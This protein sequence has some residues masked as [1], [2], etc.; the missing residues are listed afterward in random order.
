[1]A[2]LTAGVILVH[3][4]GAL[5]GA[6]AAAL[7]MHGVASA[8]ELGATADEYCQRFALRW[9]NG[10]R[11]VARDYPIMR[12]LAG[13]SFP[14]LVVEVMPAGETERSFSREWGDM[15]PRT[16]T[17]ALRIPDFNMSSVSQAS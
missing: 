13:E 1:M 17:P 9:R 3:P 15:F 4:S 8:A 7:R 2:G 6:N 10:R 11:L 12:M 14:D 5:I 16:A